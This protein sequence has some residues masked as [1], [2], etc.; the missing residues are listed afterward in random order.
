[1]RP[2]PNRR[3]RQRLR[4]RIYLVLL[5]TALVAATALGVQAYVV[6]SQ[7]EARVERVLAERL[8][9]PFTIDDVRLDLFTGLQV[10]GV[11]VAS[12]A[13]SFHPRV[14]EIG[15]ITVSFNYIAL[16]LGMNP[17]AAIQVDDPVVVL[18]E[19][20]EGAL[21][22]AR[23][24]RPA[25]ARA[26]EIRLLPWEELPAIRLENLRVETCS[27][28]VFR[29]DQ[30]LQIPRFTL[31]IPSRA[32]GEFEVRFELEQPAALR[33][34]QRAAASGVPAA[35]LIYFE[36]AGNSKAGT[37]HGSARILPV[38]LD[39]AL[40]DRFPEKFRP[41]WDR[42]SPDGLARAEIDFQIDGGKFEVPRLLLEIIDGSLTLTAPLPA[43]AP[44]G[45]RPARVTIDSLGGAFEVTRG[46]S[47]RTVT[48]LEGKVLRGDATLEG[49]MRFDG[50]DPQVVDVRLTAK[51]LPLGD[52]LRR[53]FSNYPEAVRAWDEYSPVGYA[54]VN[55]HAHGPFVRD[56]DDE[57]RLPLENIT[58]GFELHDVR[59]AHRQF[60]YP[61]EHLNGTI[62]VENRRLDIALRGIAAGEELRAGGSAVL[63][64]RGPVDIRIG[65]K[66]MPIDR[67]L[68]RARP[69][70][71][72][73]FWNDFQPSGR[74]D[75]ELWIARDDTM[76][77][78]PNILLTLSGH[79]EASAVLLPRVFP[80][81]IEEITGS[82]VVDII[83]GGVTLSD[84]RARHGANE[85]RL[86]AGRIDYGKDRPLDIDLEIESP[87]LAI[88]EDLI[89]AFSPR[90]RQVVHSFGLAGSA[91]TKVW[92]T[93]V[94]D[95]PTGAREVRTII[96]VEA[97]KPL[98][99]VYEALPYPITLVSGKAR[100]D[101]AQ[102][103]YTF[104][105]LVSDDSK[106]PRIVID[107]SFQ[108]DK[109]NPSRKVLDLD[110]AI[111]A[112]T[113]LPG[114]A[115]EDPQLVTSL[116]AEL[117]NLAERL[118]LSGYVSTSPGNPINVTY[119]YLPDE[120][121]ESTAEEVTYSALL[122]CQ[123]AKVDFGM[124]VD[125]IQAGLNVV[126]SAYPSEP[127]SFSCVAKVGH[128]RLS[129]FV[130]RDVE[131]NGRYSQPHP[132]I[133][134]ARQ[135]TFQGANEGLFQFHD[136]LLTRLGPGQHPHVLQMLI[137]NGRLYDG[138]VEGFVYVD[139]GDKKDYYADIRTRDVDL[140]VGA[141]D[142]FRKE[143]D[144][145]AGIARGN[146]T[147]WGRTDRPDGIGG[148]GTLAVENGK[149]AN[150]GFFAE[151][152]RVLKSVEN[153]FSIGGSFEDVRNITDVSARFEIERQ[154]FYVEEKE[155]RPLA[156]PLRMKGPVARLVAV[157]YMDFDQELNLTLRIEPG[158][159]IAD[160]LIKLFG[161]LGEFR[162]VGPID[163]PTMRWAPMGTGPSKE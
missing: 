141:M 157:G 136:A 59:G 40:R 5:L 1:M 34:F 44:E 84:L 96:D 135:G 133:L 22:L 64:D 78:I 151:L 152:I 39:A 121:G 161:V 65:M 131:I 56:D 155:K 30:P 109:V 158:S 14:L 36:G 85:I 120:Y 31:S 26:S 115:L 74:L 54:S 163:N 3:A 83:H 27:E 46:P 94:D 117:R 75:W 23:I 159:I 41:I 139:V 48:R 45:A 147:L 66:R 19:G 81:R 132:A 114:L 126:G 24:L 11:R 100:L 106:G 33:P 60:P 12:P 13:G 9:V 87:A 154:R 63:G 99:M 35:Q 61:V 153:P 118:R 148:H 149:L 47:F 82:A 52:D 8:A 108:N 86:P 91:K 62:G 55:V 42:F 16:L 80:Y 137:E 17:I 93:T 28:T 143:K 68:E 105:E 134:Q 162:V 98:T 58:L 111:Q 110:L 20:G 89:R 57:S 101:L 67:R 95:E 29:F 53:I 4:R 102:D 10:T 21:T 43:S 38:R 103:S 129:R 90:A 15:S 18:E 70:L 128:A 160:I 140:S 6:L 113:T 32:S 145:L 144:D 25:E 146:V 112:G 125:E 138:P 116:P 37:F 77:G 124:E 127:H 150:L 104:I 50:G 69:A 107:G 76:V 7:I 97:T 79:A 71:L 51:N 142:V 92:I 73:T 130:A 88:D 156:S 122:V 49:E 123:D 2:L 119:S 72:E